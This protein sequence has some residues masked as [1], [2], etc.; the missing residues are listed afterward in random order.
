[1]S[2]HHLLGNNLLK[3]QLVDMQDA[4]H[5]KNLE[6]AVVAAGKVRRNNPTLRHHLLG[7]SLLGALNM[8]DAHHKMLLAMAVVDQ[9]LAHHPTKQHNSLKTEVP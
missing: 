4:H 1:M 8:Q 5:K 6:V 7:N 9:V 2:H 3:V